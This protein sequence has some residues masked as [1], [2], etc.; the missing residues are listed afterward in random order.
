MAN[1]LTPVFALAK[2]VQ[3]KTAAM[4]PTINLKGNKH[5]KEKIEWTLII[6]ANAVIFTAAI[7]KHF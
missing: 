4:A 6:I 2:I 5:M 3:T 7:L 1:R